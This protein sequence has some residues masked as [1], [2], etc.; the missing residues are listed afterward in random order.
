MKIVCIGSGNVATHMAGAFKENGADIVQV[1]S[2][3]LVNAQFLAN[4]T[5][6]QAISDLKLVDKHADLYLIAVKDDAI[7]K[8]AKE[9]K[10]INGIVVHTSGATEIEVLAGFKNYGVFYPLQTFSKQQPLDFIHVPLCLEANSEES[11]SQLRLMA[12][13]LTPLIYEVDSKKR[14]I[15]HVAGV[16]ACNFVNHLYQLSHQIIKK[17]DLDFE[18]LRPLIMETAVKVQ[19]ALPEAVQTGPAIRNDKKTILKHEELLK[20]SPH[21]QEIYKNLSNSIKKSH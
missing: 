2:R 6:A 3:D 21:L 12:V 10:E 9:L 13:K 15:L 20:R 5:G 17:H 16:F 18:M 7:A 4:E 1:W 19:E 8:V 11:L 14:E